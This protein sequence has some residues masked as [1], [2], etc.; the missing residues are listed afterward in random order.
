MNV[1]EVLAG[2][3][4]RGELSPDDAGLSVAG[5]EYDSRRVGKDFLFFAFAGSRVDGRRFAQDALTRGASAVVSDQPRPSDF[6]GNWIEVEHGRRALAIASRNF[7]HRP[8]ERVNFTG[9]TGT[10]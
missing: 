10:N 8:D 2:V 3:K 7:Y 4:L 9:I 6:T 1:R 5:L